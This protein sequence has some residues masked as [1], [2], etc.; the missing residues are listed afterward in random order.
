MKM[1]ALMTQKNAVIA[2][3]IATIPMAQPSDLTARVDT[4]S[5]EFRRNPK[6]DTA[7]MISCNTPC[8]W[9]ARSSH[10]SASG[11][12]PFMAG[13]GVPLHF[14]EVSLRSTMKAPF[15]DR[16]DDRSHED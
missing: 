16:L 13:C 4:Q 1:P 14:D 5:K 15:F 12:I 2:S 11:H 7:V 8:R 9:S 3:N 6:F 10:P